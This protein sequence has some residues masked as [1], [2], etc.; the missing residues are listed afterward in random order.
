[1]AFVIRE[2]LDAGLLHEDVLTVAGPGLRHYQRE[3]VLEDGAL[4]W[5]EGRETS[6]DT[7]ILRSA[8]DP[9]DREGGIRL[10]TG[11]LGRAVIKTSA[12]RPEHRIVEA[13]AK[14]FDDQDDFLA[15]FQGGELTGDF[16][17]VVRFQGPRANGMP[18]LHS[19]SP[20]LSVL[21]DRGQKVALVT[22]GRMSGASGKTPAAIHVTPE[23]EDGGPLAYLRDGD[24]VRLDAVAG[25]L[26][27]K[28][29]PAEWRARTPAHR[30]QPQFGYGRE[31]FANMR[32][33]A[34]PAD[35]GASVLY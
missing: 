33:I 9:F 24:I 30:V 25:E 6:L 21:L 3:P 2:L 22:D 15:A 7:T 1:M 31:L 28:V 27:V 34:G 19:L 29:D 5:R 17:A 32:R 18:E 13:P 26:T 12:V 11:N 14:V 16:V 4:I 10:L 8:S 23:A 20:T 35:A